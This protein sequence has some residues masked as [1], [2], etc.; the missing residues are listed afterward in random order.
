[1]CPRAFGGKPCLHTCARHCSS[2]RPDADSR[3][4]CGYKPCPVLFGPGHMSAKGSR[5]LDA[6]PSATRIRW[7]TVGRNRCNGLDRNCLQR[8]KRSSL[9]FVNTRKGRT[10]FSFLSAE[11]NLLRSVKDLISEK[12]QKFKTE[13][14][15]EFVVS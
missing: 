13:L 1:M 4:G 2:P 3:S 8:D 10:F 5:I 6:D 12:E 15:S 9:S 11:H 7:C 14:L